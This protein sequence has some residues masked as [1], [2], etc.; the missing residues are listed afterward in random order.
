MNHKDKVIDI[1]LI[2]TSKSMDNC[3]ITYVCSPL[4]I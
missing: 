1:G 2:D 4:N 3:T